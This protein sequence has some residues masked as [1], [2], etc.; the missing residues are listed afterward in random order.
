MN[1]TDA[2]TT[3]S[4]GPNW[5]VILLIVIA[6]ATILLSIATFLLFSQTNSSKTKTANYSNPF[7]A[8]KTPTTYQNPFS[9]TTT[10]AQN[11]FSAIQL[12]NTGGNQYQNPF[13]GFQQK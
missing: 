12:S 9:T 11:P 4:S 2:N 6:S 10:T 8:Q 13:A 1:P 3:P 5:N 7:D